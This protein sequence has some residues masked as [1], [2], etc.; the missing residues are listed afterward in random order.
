[1]GAGTMFIN[2]GG[3]TM[4]TPEVKCQVN[5]CTH[6]ISQRC[7]AANI[8]ILYEE[9]GRM[10]QNVEHTQ[11]KTFEKRSSLAN[12]IGSADNVNWGGLVSEVF[13]SGQQLTPT[14]TCIVE[15]CVYWEKD[16]R[17][18][19]ESIEITGENATECQ[20]TNCGTYQNRE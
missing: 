12:L 17:C 5:T 16:N 6:W 13:A 8:D 9:E 1:M 10:A 18:V 19:A 11:C 2:Q 15:S 20:D 14:T 7:G 4:T 3:L